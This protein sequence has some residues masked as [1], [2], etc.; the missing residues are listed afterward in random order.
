MLPARG[1]HALQGSAYKHTFKPRTSDFDDFV[2]NNPVT[3]PKYYGVG[4]SDLLYDLVASQLTLSFAEGEFLTAAVSF[5]GGNHEELSALSATYPRRQRFTWDITSVSIG[6]VSQPDIIDLTYTQNENLE[7]KHTAD[8]SRGKWPRFVKRTGWRT[9]EVSGTFRFRSRDLYEDFLNQT[10]RELIVTAQ[11]LNSEVS[12]GYYSTIQLIVPTLRP[13][14]QPL[15]ADGPGP[16]DVSFT[17]KGVEN[18][19]S[20]TIAQISLINSQAAY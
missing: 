13:T 9:V 3:I 15:Q 12:S 7:I 11:D 10:E 20:G 18:V 14:D 4:S 2:A 1:R 8:V 5:M 16:I 19:G 6:D 17:Y